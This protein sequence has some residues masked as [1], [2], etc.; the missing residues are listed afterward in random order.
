MQAVYTPP[1]MSDFLKDTTWRWLE[2]G[3][4]DE[5]VWDQLRSYIP[6]ASSKTKETPQPAL[7][8]LESS[9]ALFIQILKKRAD[10][11]CQWDIFCCR[12]S[13]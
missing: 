3:D 4:V 9:K 13:R 11:K 1:N 12:T 6:P 2:V 5:T 10:D 7:S 8:P